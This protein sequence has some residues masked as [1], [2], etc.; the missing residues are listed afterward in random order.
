MYS[1]ESKFGG[2]VA[3]NQFVQLLNWKDHSLPVDSGTKVRT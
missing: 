1:C 2:P 3:Y